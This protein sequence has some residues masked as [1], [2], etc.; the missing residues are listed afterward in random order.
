MPA[1]TTLTNQPRRSAATSEETRPGNPDISWALDEFIENQRMQRIALF[2]EYYYGEHRLAF[3]TEKFRSVFGH[4]LRA[5][6]DNLCESV[7]DTFAERLEIQGFTTNQA[8]PSE[9]HITVEG[10]P[11]PEGAAPPAPTQEPPPPNAAPGSDATE[12]PAPAPGTKILVKVDDPIAEAAWDLWEAN[13]GDVIADEVHKEALMTGDSFLIVWPDVD[14]TTTL[15]PQYSHEIAVRYAPNR[16]GR[17]ELAAKFWL[18]PNKHARLTLYYE[19]HVERYVSRNKVHQ[20]SR[21]SLKPASFVPYTDDQA[22]SVV[23]NPYGR[24]P[25]FHHA[26]KAFGKYG[27]S[28]LNN[29]IPVQ[30]ALNKAVCDMLVAMEFAAFRQRWITGLEV[31]VD[32]ATGKPKDTPFDMGVDRIVSAG[33]PDAKFGEFGQTDLTQFLSVQRD[34]RAEIAR[35]VGIPL[36]YLFTNSSSGDAPSGEALK[37]SELRFARQIK[38]MQGRFGM[39]WEQAVAF[40]LDIDQGVPEDLDLNAE[41]MTESPQSQSE[42]LDGLIKLQ[43]IGVPDSHLQKMYGFDDDLINLFARQAAANQ[44]PPEPAPHD[45][46]E[47]TRSSPAQQVKDRAVPPQNQ[48]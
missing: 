1:A 44:P 10:P 6:A 16:R 4:L 20:L 18:M 7:V 12:T 29:V 35:V 46:P 3:A 39:I 11:Q 5:F 36:H 24:V 45:S 8:T 26:H 9:E 14:M 30:D 19:D 41:W 13:F 34:F 25:V 2:R 23:P 17:L 33:D 32:D 43:T 27:L 37:T 15:W 38:K 21:S 48:R 47:E 28:S 42:Q 40:A 31:E 22:G